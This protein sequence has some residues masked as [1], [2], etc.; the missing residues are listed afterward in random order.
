LLHVSA[1]TAPR[2]QYV[3]CS[4]MELRNLIKRFALL[5][6]AAGMLVGVFATDAA[7]IIWCIFGQ[8]DFYFRGLGGSFSHL[9]SMILL[10]CFAGMLQGVLLL[11][12]EI[13]F[14][15]SINIPRFLFTQSLILVFSYSIIVS[16]AFS[17]NEIF[18]NPFYEPLIFIAFGIMLGLFLS[19][20][21]ST[22]PL[23]SADPKGRAAD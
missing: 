7:I 15:R 17:K 8:P 4:K 21:A 18:W 2:E 19:K 14:K 6:I 1:K 23:N 11:L 22:E 12:I 5:G 10:F 16:F 9:M 13:I 20:K 3:L